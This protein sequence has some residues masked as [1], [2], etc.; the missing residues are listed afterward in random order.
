MKTNNKKNIKHIIELKNIVKTFDNN[1][2]VLNNIDLKINRGEFVTLLGPSGSGKTT[3]LRL[4][5]GF[6]WATRGEIKFNGR[7][8]KD[9]SPHKRNVSTIFQDYAL[10]THLNVYGNILYGLKLKRVPKD[11]VSSYR[12]N[13][14][15]KKKVAWEAKAKAK[16]VEL[17][18][19][20]D[21]YLEELQT[22]KPGTFKF[23]KR[24]SW[25][26]DSDFKYSYWENFV[27]LKVQD[28]ENKY[29]KR[30]MTKDELN[31]K[32]KRI[33]EIVGLSGNETKSISEL[34][35]GMK[36][37][38]ALARSLVIEPE[39]LL[40]DEPLSALDAKIRQRMQVLLR[41]VQQEL[42]LTFIFVTHDQDEALE[43]SD[44]IAIMRDGI[45]EQYDTPKNIYDY[46]VNIWVAKFIGDS[47]VFNAK[48]AE[49]GNV[50]LFGREYKTIHED[51]EFPKN[52]EV[53]VLIRPE[54]I[55]ITSGTQVKKDGK[56]VGQVIDVSYRGSYYY[57]KIE[58]NDGNIFNVET[59]KKFEL[60]ETVYLSWTIDSIHLMKKDPK[61]DYNHNEFK[62]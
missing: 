56:I 20:Q 61:W 14:L 13:E 49:D 27:D 24:Q 22:L 58:A 5:G 39:I 11:T 38:V 59:A 54:D 62:N 52:T 55:D 6:E 30:R 32:T 26:D 16:M 21:K 29:F 48:M 12:L 42:G 50:K 15:E 41:S 8:I 25:L 3:I 40:L 18:K 57:L 34:S 7:D 2:T 31:E 44:R 4:I 60:N 45:I 28:Y 43:L 1:K 37:R 36:Q 53:D 9:L 46:P 10:F 51:D 19:I 23:N 17:D 33:I 35:G 47:N